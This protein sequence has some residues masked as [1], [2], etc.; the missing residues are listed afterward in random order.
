MRTKSEKVYDFDKMEAWI[1]AIRAS[2]KISQTSLAMQCG[3]SKRTAEGW[4]CKKW[5]SGSTRIILGQLALVAK[6][7]PFDSFEKKEDE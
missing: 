6:V 7:A 1:K 4:E 5:P 3:V 2:L